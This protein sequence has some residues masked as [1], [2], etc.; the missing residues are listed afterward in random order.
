MSRDDCPEPML[1][2]APCA[3][4]VEVPTRREQEALKKLKAI[5]VRVRELKQARG[6]TGK[7]F[8]D[9]TPDA[10]ERELHYLKGE[11]ERWEKERKEAARE[12]MILLGH[13]EA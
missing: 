9:E 6:Q 1:P 5:K 2:I 13:E 12:R 11:W 3:E 10:I 8:A 7:A 4:A